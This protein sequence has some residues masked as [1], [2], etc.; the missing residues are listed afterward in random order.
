MF[1]LFGVL[2]LYNGHLVIQTLRKGGGGAEV[3]SKNL[4]SALWASVWSKYKAG[5]SGPPG[6]LPW[7]RH[8]TESSVTLHT[9]AAM[10]CLL[11]YQP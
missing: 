11:S 2:F 6:P 4:F 8:C 7:I 9:V 5:G 10:L 3:V 1:Y